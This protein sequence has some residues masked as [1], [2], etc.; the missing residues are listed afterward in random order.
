MKRYRDVA[1]IA[2]ILIVISA[3]LYIF[4]YFTFH[5]PH[6]IFIFMLGDLAFLPLEVLIVG[7]VVER[8]LSRR[9]M[10]E[11]LQKLNMVVGAFFSEIG[12]RLMTT[13]MEATAQK[14]DVIAHIDVT[15]NWTD[16]DY[17]KARNFI[18]SIDPLRFESIDLEQLKTYLV[19]KRPFML[20]L[21]ENPNLLEHERFTDLLLAVFHLTEEL[22]S[23]PQVVNLPER[24]IA[25]IY[26]D[27]NRIYKSSITQWLEYMAHLK[28]NY[29]FLY[30]HYLRI[31]PFQLHPSAIIE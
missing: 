26:G 1:I 9:E 4:H 18:E 20:A 12:H 13:L 21:I 17:K 19:G 7:I 31:H 6:H 10:E 5:D 2:A 15:P 3:G 23:R 14:D 11:R 30:S 8:I 27:I 25:H 29:P 28:S 24:D 22:E 16:A